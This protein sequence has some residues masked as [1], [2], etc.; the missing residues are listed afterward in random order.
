M[1]RTHVEIHRVAVSFFVVVHCPSVQHHHCVLGDILPVIRK[2]FRR[3][4]RRAEPERVVAP[5]DF[6][7]DSVDVRK[8]CL[9]FHIREPITAH[10]SVKLLLGS[11]LNLGV[12]WY[13]GREP[14]HDR[15]RLHSCSVSEVYVVDDCLKAES[16]RPSQRRRS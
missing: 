2:V 8:G 14:L 7:D 16:D 1:M 4:M 11:L 6:L 10:N 12:G 3:N 5:L 9:V 13:Q 15:S